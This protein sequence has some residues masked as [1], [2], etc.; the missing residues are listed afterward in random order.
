VDYQ[1]SYDFGLNLLHFGYM[2][3]LTVLTGDRPTGKLHLG[4][5]VGSIQNRLKL[6]DEAAANGGQAFYMIADVQAFTD[7]ADNP[8]KVRANVLEIA[9]D[10]L[11]MGIDPSKTIMFIQSKV[12]E[13]AELTIFFLNLV[14]LAR[15]KR[16]PTVKSEMKQKD[17]EE[18]VPAGFLMYPVSQAADILVFKANMIPV[19]DDQLPMIE[20]T[21]EIV[22][23]FNRFYGND[24]FQHV[25]HK[26]GDTA[27]LIGIDGNAKMSKSLGNG[28]YLSDDEETIRAKV[29]Q[30]YTDPN[31]IHLQ[32]PGQV[33]GNVVFTYLD[34]FDTDKEAVADL[35]KQYAAGGLGD[36]A[37]KDRLATI[38]IEKFA[39]FRTR[40]AALEKDP[41]AV[42]KILERGTDRAREVAHE[43]MLEVRRAM[44]IDY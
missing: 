22:D 33:E 39:D 36:V 5:Y 6:Q 13:I 9:M 32:D 40:R 2:K 7:N 38:L 35:K 8:D 15:L 4:H 16:N 34:V 31:H 30:M 24:V 11:A 37:I 14:T 20:Q 19:G 42:M 17:F 1:L 12:P 10:N 18:D 41:E 21:N 44:K 26:V 27:R 29:K 25:T 43:T 3:K 23:K 28:I